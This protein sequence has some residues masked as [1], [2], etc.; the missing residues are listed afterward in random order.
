MEPGRAGRYYI[1]MNALP[2]VRLG[3]ALGLL[4]F[5]ATGLVTRVSGQA[6][7]STTSADGGAHWS[8][9]KNDTYDQRDHFAAGAEGLSKRLDEEVRRLKAKRATMT[10]DTKDWDFAMKAV[11]DAQSLLIS[12]RTELSKAT[13]PE[14]WADAKQK[15]GDA[16]KQ[17]Q[18]AV[19]KMNSTV[20]S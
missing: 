15:V 20:T 9:I 17:A 2:H 3:L 18:L 8:D 7:I 10:T 14:A 12:R 19:D 11:I 6:V 5:S 16:W 13:T 1:R 4:G